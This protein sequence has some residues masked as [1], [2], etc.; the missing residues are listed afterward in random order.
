MDVQLKVLETEEDYTRALEDLDRVFSAEAGTPEA[1][2][3]D[4]LG[5]LIEKY[6]DKH[7]PIDLPSPLAAIAFRM[8][9]AGLAPKDLVPY[10]G[11]RSR[12]SE[13]L[14]GKRELSLAM[15][16]ALVA[17]LGI[18]AEIL[19]R[20]PRTPLPAELAGTGWQDLP[21]TA[22]AKNGA[23]DGFSW[24]G[25]SLKEKSEEAVSWLVDQA[26]GTAAQ[27]SFAYRKTDA[28]RV[29][30][31]L[32]RGALL[33]WGLQALKEARSANLPVAFDPELLTEG[34]LKTLVS[35]SVSEDGPK[36]AREYL[37]QVGILLLILP[38]LPHTYLDGAVFWVGNR[39]V[40]ALT[41]RYDRLDNFWFVLTHELGHLAKGHLSGEVR[42]IA[43]DLEQDGDS[44]REREADEFALNTLLPA[45]ELGEVSFM[46]AAEV[47]LY[48][49]RRGVH[50]S[51][52]AGRIRHER[53]DYRLFTNLLGRGQV[54][55][56]FET[57]ERQ[58]KKTAKEE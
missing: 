51:I 23:F 49:R 14:S 34:F 24:D 58:W 41:L 43:D 50:P 28:T 11:S 33:G 30:A 29:S 8:E 4:V 26:G 57:E 42:W 52:V 38:H 31:K 19:I 35:L 54:R 17:N 2:L 32:D 53:K 40:I 7:F 44:D 22:M 55:K 1:Q 46:A 25:A 56:H 37:A 13:V 10:L 3:R 39:P 18:P 47:I 16:R 6:E 48:A 20:A 9:Q 27:G 36:L 15:I 5:V 21:L 12:V 45:F